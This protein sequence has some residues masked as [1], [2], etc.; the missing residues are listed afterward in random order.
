MARKKD[1][2][3]NDRVIVT[4]DI[5]RRIVTGRVTGV[6]RNIGHKW[7]NVRADDGTLYLEQHSERVKLERTRDKVSS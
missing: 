7:Y 6:V 2:A 5:T 3:V 1:I 4:L